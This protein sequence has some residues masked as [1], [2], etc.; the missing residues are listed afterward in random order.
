MMRLRRNDDPIATVPDTLAL[1]VISNFCVGELVPIPTFCD[2]SI[3]N[4]VVPPVCKDKVV[5]LL[6][7]GDV[8][9]VEAVRLVTVGVAEYAGATPTPPDTRTEPVAT[10]ANLDNAVEDDAY[11]KSP[12][13]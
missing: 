11:N 8:K 2:A 3:Y 5:L 12:T 6:W 4:P 7:I 10:S 9:L 1:P 13:V